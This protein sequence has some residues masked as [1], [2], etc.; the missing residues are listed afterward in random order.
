MRFLIIG[1]SRFTGPI[2]T[3]RLLSRGHEV[4]LFNRGISGFTPEGAKHIQGNR[5]SGFWKVAEHFDTVIDT[6]AFSGADT[7]QAINNID[8]DFFLHFGTA[9][10][11]RKTGKL[12]FTEDSPLGPWPI[13]GS[14]NRGKVECEKVLSSSGT[15]YATIRPV[16][17]L[18]PNDYT[19]REG[20]IFS[21]IGKNEIRIP[22]GGDAKVQF[23][24]SDE[25]AEAFAL[26]GECQMKG[27]FN[28]A[29]D[30]VTTLKGL[31]EKMAQVKGEVVDIRADP[32]T[33]T[34][35][36]PYANEDFFCTNKKLKSLG[37]EFR[38][39]DDG[40]KSDYENYYSHHVF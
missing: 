12:P 15:D 31:V 22:G 2:I 36:F 28:C 30:E 29:G 6:C 13:W 20:F 27:A 9:A 18:G 26:I 38:S 4:T 11:Y 5:K 14:Y 35:E 7:L 19:R 37:L 23:V 32:Q 24:F 40:L 10:A 34:S 25:V 21:K 17:I 3:E 8:F 16:Y 33:D 1:G 39:L